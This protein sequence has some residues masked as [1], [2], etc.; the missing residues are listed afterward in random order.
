MVR[1]TYAHWFYLSFTMF[2]TTLWILACAS[3]SAVPDMVSFWRSPLRSKGSLWWSNVSNIFGRGSE[4]A[5]NVLTISAWSGSYV[6]SSLFGG[7]CYFL[8]VANHLTARLAAFSR[9]LA[10]P[11]VP[12]FLGGSQIY[13]KD[14]FSLVIC[15]LGSPLPDFFSRLMFQRDASLL[16]EGIFCVAIFNHVLWGGEDKIEIIKNC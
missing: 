8:Q 10:C 15:V 16:Y 6:L 2:S 9:D 14:C 1:L 12:G 11:L 13:W 5:G 3:F 4:L 7:L